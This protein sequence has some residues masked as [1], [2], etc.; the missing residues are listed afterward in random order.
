MTTITEQAPRLSRARLHDW[1]LPM[2]LRFQADEDLNQ[3]IVDGL[4]R[5]ERAVDFQRTREAGIIGL[6]DPE[7]LAI[8]A[9]E[10]RLLVSRDRKT[11][12]GHFAHFIQHQSSPGLVMISQ[13]LE[14]GRAIEDPLSIWVAMDSEECRDHCIFLPL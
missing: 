5:C 11:M 13:D 7:V 10:N 6:P 2:T 12:L 4:L 8:A 9:R 3:K 1:Q 14:I